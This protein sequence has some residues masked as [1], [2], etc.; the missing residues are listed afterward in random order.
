MPFALVTAGTSLQLVNADGT[1]QTLTLPADVTVLS[2]YRLRGAVLDRAVVGVNAPTRPIWVDPDGAVRPLHVPPPI[3]GPTLAAGAAGGL[4]GTFTAKHSNLIKDDLGRVL[5]ESPLSRASV[6]VTVAAQ[7]IAGT[8]PVAVGSANVNARRVY[9]TTTNGTVYFP[10]FDLDDNTTTEY[11]DDA[12]DAALGLVAAPT[13]LGSPPSRFTL[14]VEWK[15]R[16]WAV[17]PADVDML[18]GSGL[19]KVFAWPAALQNP[20]RPVGADTYGITGFLPR[21]DELGIGKRNV[22]WK[23]I[24]DSED[25]FALKKVVEGTGVL[26]PDSCIV[27]RD[28]GYFLGSGVGGFGVFAWS[29]AGVS[30]ISDDLVHP[31]FNTDTYF[32]RGQFPNAV[33]AYDPLKHAVLLFLSA[34]GS[35]TL[36]RWVSYDIEGKRWLGPHITAALTPTCAGVLKDTNELD[37]AVIGASDGYLYTSTPGNYSDGTA[38]AI[39]FDVTGKFHAGA[40]PAP[41]IEHFFGQLSVL[42]KAEVAGTLDIIP[43]VGDLTVAAGT[44]MTHDLTLERERLARLG[45]GRLCQLRFRQNTA[46]QG[47]EL[48]GYEIPWHEV[49]RR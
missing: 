21:R 27:V 39:D 45:T 36:D 37:R 2:G 35:T 33:A 4:T 26:A 11:S 34:P 17:S 28:V 43:K 31:W 20:V 42:T 18:Y 44:T 8:I 19:R 32:A 7:L 47:V 13:D 9:R 5:A 25:T 1:I 29:S 30:S 14:L 16:L 24:G 22:L 48:Y 15:G 46:G 10:W 23:M 6:A 38:S 41:D 12:S 40:P 3:T 49:G